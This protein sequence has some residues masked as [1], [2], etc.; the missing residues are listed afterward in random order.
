MERDGITGLAKAVV[1]KMTHEPSVS[2]PVEVAPDP[3]DEDRHMFHWGRDNLV[4]LLRYTKYTVSKEHWQKEP[5][6]FVIYVSA[7]K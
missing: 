4:D 3:V 5:Y 2:V 6:S 7:K 1:Q